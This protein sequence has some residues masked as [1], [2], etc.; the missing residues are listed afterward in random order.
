MISLYLS[1]VET[2]LQTMPQLL[3][4]DFTWRTHVEIEMIVHWRYFL[5]NNCW[6]P[7]VQA[8][9]VE[10]CCHGGL[11]TAEAPS[12]FWWAC[13]KHQLDLFK[14]G[15]AGVAL[16]LWFV[17]CQKWQV[18]CVGDASVLSDVIAQQ[19]TKRKHITGFARKS[20]GVWYWTNM[21]AGAEPSSLQYTV[22]TWLSVLLFT[23]CCPQ[24]CCFCSLYHMLRIKV[25]LFLTSIH[26]WLVFAACLDQRLCYGGGLLNNKVETWRPNR[27]REKPTFQ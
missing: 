17:W 8:S 11:H 10:Y 24:S 19:G 14:C 21:A 5:I 18:A 9:C 12:A 7:R 3:L 2:K 4:I 6:E 27:R 20:S 26:V 25:R 16:P 23:C 22:Y 15:R 13:R 1:K